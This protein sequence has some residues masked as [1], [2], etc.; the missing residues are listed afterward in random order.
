MSKFRQIILVS[1]LACAGVA[2]AAIPGLLDEGQSARAKFVQVGQAP[3]PLAPTSGSAMV[4][5]GGQPAA[6]LSK[7]QVGGPPTTTANTP[8]ANQTV[9]NAPSN[10]VTAVAQTTTALTQLRNQL[11]AVTQSAQMMQQLNMQ[12][13]RQ[14]Q[15]QNKAL[16]TEISQLTQAM[17][18][19]H[20]QVVRL[21]TQVAQRS[22][23]SAPQV[24]AGATLS[25][26]AKQFWRQLWQH[27]VF[28]WITGAAAVLLLVLIA[29]GY[30]QAKPKPDAP[31][32]QPQDSDYDFLSSVEAI[33]AKLDLARAYLAMDDT[34]A[35][36]RV[37]SDVME[38]GNTEQQ[39]EAQSLLEQMANAPS[40]SDPA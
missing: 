30:R 6:Q 35:A 10:N 23:I 33:P 3:K 8:G 24:V 11:T 16:Q 1:L 26:S 7:V 39:K 29:W 40:S 13:L 21:G 14:L 4:Q 20:Q 27:S 28:K 2:Q 12:Q 15:G 36:K 9:A 19:M 17:T 22:A 31:A 5:V 25:G 34:H 37:L 32:Q 18:I 38:Q